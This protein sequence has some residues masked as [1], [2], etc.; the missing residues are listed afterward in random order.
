MKFKKFKNS[1]VK[2]LIHVLVS[3]SNFKSTFSNISTLAMIL[4][5]ISVTTAT[6]ERNF[7]EMKQ[8][9]EIDCVMKY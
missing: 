2:D 8:G 1:T 5:V 6:V 7:S 3:N 9:S 4:S